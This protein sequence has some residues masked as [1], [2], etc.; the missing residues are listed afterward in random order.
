MSKQ[1]SNRKHSDEKV[2]PVQGVTVNSDNGA[3]N[4]TKHN[5]DV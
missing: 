3:K 1:K 4:N 2:S 5:T